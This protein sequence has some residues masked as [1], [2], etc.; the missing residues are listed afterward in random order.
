MENNA[1]LLYLHLSIFYKYVSVND[2][3]LLLQEYKT[4]AS[5]NITVIDNVASSK[6]FYH[7]YDVMLVPLWSGSG[8]R[9]KLVEGLAYGKPIITTTIGAEG[10]AYTHNENLLIADNAD[11]FANAIVDV[12]QNPQ[13]KQSLQT[14]ARLLAETNFDYKVIAKKLIAFCENLV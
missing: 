1:R 8:L 3:K 4:K 7:T 12:L 14:K 13:L 6:E 9:I 10:I 5:T 11:D 2:E